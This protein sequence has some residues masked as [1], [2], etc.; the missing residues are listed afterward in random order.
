[1]TLAKSKVQQNPKL[2]DSGSSCRQHNG[3]SHRNYY[4]NPRVSDVESRVVKKEEREPPAQTGEVGAPESRD[5]FIRRSTLV[6]PC[7][8]KLS[9]YD[10]LLVT[11][12]EVLNARL[13]V[14]SSRLRIL[15]RIGRGG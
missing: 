11:L 5:L 13:V 7:P 8:T 12:K 6:A 9:A 3:Q 10:I 15:S 1:M 14:P 4:V 2:L